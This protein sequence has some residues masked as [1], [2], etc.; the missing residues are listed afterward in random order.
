MAEITGTSGDDTLNGTGADDVINGL[1]GNDTIAGDAGRDTIDGGD[2]NDDIRGGSGGDT[3]YDGAGNDAA[4]GDLDQDI[5]YSSA[6]D[7]FYDAGTGFLQDNFEFDQVVYLGAAAGIVVDLRLSTGQVRSAG[8]ADAAK[9]GVDTLIGFE[10]VGGSPFNDLMTAGDVGMLFAGAGGDDM[11][12]GGPGQ[13]QLSG[14][15]GNDVL[16]GNGGADALFGQEGDDVL[17]GGAGAD[18]L[19]GGAGGDVF[20]DTAANLNGDTISG[21]ERGDRIVLTDAVLGS[22]L[23]WTGTQ[24]TYGSTSINLTTLN[25][26]SIAVGPAPGGGVEIAYGGPPLVFAAGPG[27]SRSLNAASLPSKPGMGEWIGIA[28]DPY[29]PPLTDF[30]GDQRDFF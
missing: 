8:G 22:G 26:A 7:D 11:L 29:A 24:L 12:V 23:G 20:T 4:Y 5:F 16:V 9:I 10:L 13:D 19:I 15:E 3:I 25:N 27:V 2:G 28:Q 21:F 30:Y 17:T 18:Y 1:G 14:D 6:G